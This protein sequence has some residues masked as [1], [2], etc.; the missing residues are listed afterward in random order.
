MRARGLRVT[1]QRRAV[2]EVFDGADV[3]LTAE[4]VHRAASRALPELSLAT[5]YNTLNTMVAAGLLAESHHLPG[6]TRYDPAQQPHHH[7]VCR[8][9]HRLVDV[10]A[11]AVGPV[12]LDDDHRP[13]F[14]VDSVEITFHGLCGEC[15]SLTAAAPDPPGG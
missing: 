10:A 1:A 11:D 9:C 8:R 14:A 2:A 3:H 13:R 6:P 7:L 4:D 15:R 5:V 12:A